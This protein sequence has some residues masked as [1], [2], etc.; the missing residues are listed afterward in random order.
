MKK[1]KT[2]KKKN[3][4]KFHWIFLLIGASFFILVIYRLC[5]LALSTKIDGINIQEFASSRN[6]TTRI[7][8][9]ERGRIYDVNG[10]VLAENVSSYTLIAYLD[11][12]RTNDIKN[13]KHVVDKEFTA[14]ELSKVLD[15]KY[16]DILK[17]L[18]K[19]GVYQTE[20]GSKAKGLSELEKDR[21]KDLNLPGIG[22]IETKKRYY[23]YGDFM[24]YTI[25]YAV[26][27]VV[28]DDNGNKVTKL[29][30][31]MGIE[32]YYDDILSGKDGYTFYQRDRNGYKI[33][34]TSEITVKAINGSDIYLSL[35]ANVGM[36]LEQ[37][38]D[39][40][41]SKKYKWEWYTMIVAD[42]KTGAI[43][44]AVS[45]PSFDPNKRNI[46]N[47]LD[48]NTG[49]AF[50]PGSTMKTWTYMAVMENS[51]YNPNGK[52]K[53]GTYTASD[54]TEIGDWK[55]SG[56]GNITYD[57]GFALSS[58]TGIISLLRKNI[59]K[60]TLRGYYSKLGFGTTT[61]V[62]I[63]NEVNGKIAFKYETEYYNA[64]FGQG[65]TTTPI[66]NIKALTSISNDGMLLQPYYVD[67]IVDSDG[68]IS[69]KG[70]R[71]ELY[72]VASK[73]TTDKM[74]DLMEDVIA[75]NSATCTGYPYYMEGYDLIIK[76]GSAQVAS[77][78]GYNTGEVIK[79]IAGMWPKNDP[80]LIFYVA[81]K[82]PNDGKGGRV[83]PMSTVVKELVKNISSYYE[84]YSSKKKSTVISKIDKSIKL[85]SY[86]NKDT[87]KVKDILKN[88]GFKPIIIGNGNKIIKQHPNNNTVVT[89]KDK[90]FLITNDDD[91]RIPNV[92]GYSLSDARTLLNMLNIK[93]TYEGNGYVYK[94]SINP[95]EK[96][97]DNELVLYL[98]DTYIKEDVNNKKEEEKK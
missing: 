61:G 86:I 72:Q 93:Y 32:K 17:R 65:I 95:G 68:T 78:K 83:A 11:P 26:E 36:F 66:Q 45:N 31:E 54:G 89:P 39:N 82:K 64:G 18:N 24:S 37:A 84:I 34:G 4:I 70:G 81:A 30:G 85:D 51:K 74:K 75:G 21:I 47:Y 67:K 77:G 76:T 63:P 87:N 53:S 49:V 92:I 33:P 91:I 13:P 69:Y 73:S 96:I 20:F 98:K 14:R 57:R 97:T 29:V 88:E 38:L 2:D 60:D 40:A 42:A 79:G 8:T 56:W 10:N 28:E 50:E 27:K 9:A 90:I 19:E 62:P 5:F 16:E 6:S 41:S 58:N 43:L 12:K 80:K 7:L 71:T 3:T 44:G 59:N 1:K 94:Q 48:Y 55:R 23:P 52:Y 35:D 15:I 25:G 46:K 22:F